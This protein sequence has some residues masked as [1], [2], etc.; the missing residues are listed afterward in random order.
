MGLKWEKVESDDHS[1][2]SRV[3]VPWG[4]LVNNMD[5]VITQTYQGYSHPVPER[6]YEWRNTLT[7]VFDPFHWWKL[8]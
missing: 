5:D 1:S 6:N 8:G 2:L 7:F 3:K 4:W